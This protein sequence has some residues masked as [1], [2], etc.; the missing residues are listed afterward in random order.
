MSPIN[1]DTQEWYDYQDTRLGVI[2]DEWWDKKVEPDS[3]GILSS[4]ER[5][6][7]ALVVPGEFKRLHDPITAFMNLPGGLQRFVLKRLSLD[8][9]IGRPVGDLNF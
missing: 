4:T 6:S 7:I 3:F 1:S 2:V 8:E 5:I 9:L